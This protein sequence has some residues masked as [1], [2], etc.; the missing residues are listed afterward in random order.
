MKKI[1][2]RSVLSISLLLLI[3]GVSYADNFCF[4][5]LA[6][7]SAV[8]GG[9]DAVTNIKGNSFV[10]G[11]SGVYNEDEYEIVFGRAMIKN[12]LPVDGLLGMLGFKGAWGEAEKRRR[13]GDMSNIAFSLS[14]AYDLSIAYSARLPI[15]LSATVNYAP[16]PLCFRDS[17]EFLEALAEIDW[18]VLRNA[19]LVA[20]YR[21][22]EIDFDNGP[23][24]EKTDN[25]GY[26]GL[27][28]S[29]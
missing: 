27:K 24:W 10:T 2:I 8:D 19:A 5:L 12:K 21:Y 17:D 20:R 11:L 22:I 13:E 7:R 15:T 23:R 14:A 1:I 28:F 9:F 16:Q 25:T 29:F 18:K 3:A 6:N 26:V 4:T